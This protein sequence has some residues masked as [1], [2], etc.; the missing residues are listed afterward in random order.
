MS[1]AVAANGGATAKEAETEAVEPTQEEMVAPLRERWV[2]VGVHSGDQHN[3]CFRPWTVRQWGTFMR[4]SARLRAARI[5]EERNA[6]AALAREA[7]AEV[8]K[9]GHLDFADRR[10]TVLT[11]ALVNVYNDDA[12]LD[13]YSQITGLDTEWCEANFDMR[14]FM[15]CLD[16]FTDFNPLMQVLSVFAMVVSR[17]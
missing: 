2:T 4:W 16:A 6:L 1:R 17:G 12:I 11:D 13:F 15:E 7:D 5:N 3:V 14:E 8:A 9:N 10:N